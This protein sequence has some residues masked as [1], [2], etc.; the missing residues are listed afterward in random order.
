MAGCLS[1]IGSGRCGRIRG[2]GSGWSWS[3][4][5]Y[6]CFCFYVPSFP[7]SSSAIVTR[8]SL[9]ISSFLSSLI[10]LPFLSFLCLSLAFPVFDI[11]QYLMSA[12]R[13]A[14]S[15]EKEAANDENG[16]STTDGTPTS[17]HAG[18]KASASATAPSSSRKKLAAWDWS[19][20][21]TY[22]VNLGNWLLLERWMDEGFWLEQSEIAALPN[23]SNT[24]LAV[25]DELS[26]V[27]VLGKEK[28]TEVLRKHWE[29]FVT[30]D[31]I[32]ILA[33][34]GV[35]HVRIPIG[36]WALMQPLDS[37]TFLFDRQMDAVKG[38][39]PACAQYGIHI[40]LDLHGMPGSQAQLAM[41]TGYETSDPQWFNA[42]NQKRSL[43][44]VGLALDWIENSGY[45]DLFAGLEVVNEPALARP[46][47]FQQSDL[48][49]MQDFYTKAYELFLKRTKWTGAMLFHNGYAP[50]GVQYWRDWAQARASTGRLV[51]IDHSYPGN[52]PA[53]T[54]LNLVQTMLCQIVNT[55]YASFPIPITVNE[56][57]LVTGVFDDAWTKLY[58]EWQMT[59]YNRFSGSVIWN[60]RTFIHTPRIIAPVP[61][62]IRLYSWEAMLKQGVIPN[63]P[64]LSKG[65]DAASDSTQSKLQSWID[66]LGP[67]DPC[68]TPY[69]GLATTTYAGL[70][71]APTG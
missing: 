32:A 8:Q 44:V 1:G 47:Q 42:D 15:Q 13:D 26:F 56:W 68:A 43:T 55:Q 58:F 31:D 35:N 22:G 34:A 4:S 9:L 61:D 53:K 66:G 28:A 12:F 17:V 5:G 2:G 19:K 37:E 62:R 48:A 63:A 23:P 10:P 7:P 54:D 49:V 69:Y 36:W 46:A 39:L 57:S 60:Y 51:I 38:I 65:D 41:T 14:R 29:T 16:G 11:G 64:A 30:S 27:R 18:P 25:P 33:A 21:K 3:F 67:S 20:H 71:G 45:D 24:T 40:T 6:C 50:G 70:A 52:Y 59:L